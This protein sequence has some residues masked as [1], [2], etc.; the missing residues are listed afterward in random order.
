MSFELVAKRRWA[1]KRKLLPR[2][3]LKYPND[4]ELKELARLAKVDDASFFSEHIRSLILDAFLNDSSFR[5]LSTPRTRTF[6][7][8]IARQAQQLGNSL[9]A[10]DVGSSGSAERSGFLLELE[11]SNI[12]FNDCSIC[13]PDYIAVLGSLTESAN[14][15][16]S[17]LKSKRG[18]KGAGGNLAFNL[19]I[20]GLLMAARQRDRRW[21]V[22]RSPNGKWSGTLL[23]ALTILQQY[24][25][26]Q[27]FPVGAE[28]GRSVEHVRKK[29]QGPHRKESRTATVIFGPFPN[30]VLR[31]LSP[32]SAIMRERLLGYVP[33]VVARTYESAQG[34]GNQRGPPTTATPTGN[35]HRRVLRVLR[36]RPYDGIRGT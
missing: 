22:Y 18:P 13:L 20:D 21:T 4:R 36:P 35:E 5:E 3:K 33:A 11:L 16:A 8:N 19:F 1:R 10:I 2:L 6:L 9:R 26:P 25:P 31:V 17:S 32:R 15:A 14:K 7:K 34:L 27:F 30:R 12:Q 28:L 29:T 24:L 23:Q